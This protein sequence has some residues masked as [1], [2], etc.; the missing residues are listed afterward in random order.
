MGYKNLRQSI[1]LSQGLLFC[2]PDSDKSSMRRVVPFSAGFGRPRQ[3]G[4]AQAPEA[5]FHIK[6]T[7]RTA[8]LGGEKGS[9][10]G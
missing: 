5:F 2:S 8:R 4:K 10:A 9:A 6:L 1:L 7:G 3:A